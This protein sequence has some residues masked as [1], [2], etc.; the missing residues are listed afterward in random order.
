MDGRCKII[1]LTLTGIS[2]G[3][4]AA[5]DAVTND[6][7]YAGANNSG[8]LVLV[9]GNVLSGNYL[10]RPDGYDV[11]VAG[12]RVFVNSQ[13]VRIVANDLQDAYERMREAYT[14]LTPEIHMEL[15]RWCLR[16]NMPDNAQREVLDALNLDP[17]RGDARRMLE[18]LLEKSSPQFSEFPPLTRTSVPKTE[19]RSLAGLSRS[20]AQDF[21]R[22]V[23]PLLMNKCANSGCHGGS[24]ISSFKLASAHRGTSPLIA[25]QNLAAVLKQID[26]SD[27][28]ASPLL[29]AMQGAH[30]DLRSP[31]FRGRSGAMQMDALRSW[32][33]TVAN[34]IAPRSNYETEEI[35]SRIALV[36]SETVE[37]SDPAV[38]SRRGSVPHGRELTTAE[39]DAEFLRDAAR[40][41][42]RDAFDPSVFNK[43][44]HGNAGVESSDKSAGENYSAETRPVVSGP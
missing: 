10:P 27:P 8:I 22:H 37:E 23:Q 13:R 5:Q 36:S 11:E 28:D 2:Q 32:V 31:I 18:N 19:V 20:V 41:H 14:A 21:T 44:F 33:A 9:D 43:R 7:S 16:N 29:S 15:A 12:G 6:A 17:N 38:P 1:F 24:S 42:V 4:A 40:A 3:I 26:L 30:G 34:D 25:E 35:G 39:T